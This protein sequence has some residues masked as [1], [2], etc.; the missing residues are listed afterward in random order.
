[1]VSYR[2]DDFQ[3]GLLLFCHQ[4]SLQY[5]LAFYPLLHQTEVCCSE[6]QPMVLSGQ[7][8]WSELKA[9]SVPTDESELTDESVQK[10]STE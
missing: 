3:G 8:A 1:M 10:A 5:C 9:W 4:D 6:D 2:Q 7:T